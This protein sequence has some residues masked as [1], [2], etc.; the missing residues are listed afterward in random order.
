MLI[1]ALIQ[2]GLPV[3]AKLFSV[4]GCVLHGFLLGMPPLLWNVLL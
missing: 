4:S 2:A 1:V 3:P